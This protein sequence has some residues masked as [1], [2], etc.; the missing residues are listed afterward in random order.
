M[1]S[2]VEI[3]VVIVCY[4]SDDY[5][6]G[7]IDSIINHSDLAQDRFEIIVV[8]N[9]P[10]EDADR[11][12]KNLR[13][14]YDFRNLLLIHNSHNGGY[15]H[16]NNVG[17]RNSTGKYICIMNPDV[18]LL[19]SLFKDVLLKFHDPEL[20]LLGYRQTGGFNLSF[21]IKPEFKSAVSGWKTRLI[22]KFQVFDSRKHYL[23]GAF[24]FVKRDIF[25]EV[26]LFDESIFM[27]F[28]E[29]DIANRLAAKKY[30]IDYDPSKKYLHLVGD[31]L[32]WSPQ[33]FSLEMKSL[34]Y[35]LKKFNIPEN[36]NI[37]RY[38]AEYQLKI[39]A[40]KILN[41]KERL[42]KFRKE[43]AY[44]KNMFKKKC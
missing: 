5:I 43:V 13:E 27:Y 25:E 20:A 40:A 21:Y 1:G 39:L 18:R 33:S 19:Q 22:N 8:D 10:K 26:G 16:G 37:R 24:F 34:K 31:R 35:Y 29:P 38:L 15:G 17:I 23:S 9:S 32:G 28:E 6:V 12:F 30:R 11:N 36:T 2:A 4:K 14:R 3:S 7:C 41:D 42:D 44:I